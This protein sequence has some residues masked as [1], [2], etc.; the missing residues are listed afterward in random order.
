[1]SD[2][3][4]LIDALIIAG[5]A[6]WMMFPALVTGPFAVLFGGGRPIDFGRRDKKGR[7]LLGGGKTWSGLGWGV[8]G[9]VAVGCAMELIYWYA[10]DWG[11]EYLIDFSPGAGSAL[12]FVGLLLAVCLGAMFGDLLF[13]FCKRKVGLKRGKRAPLVDQLDFLAG[14]WVFMVIFYPVWT[15]DNFSAWHAI[16][17]LI[18]VPILHVITNLIAFKIG[19]KK[20]P[21]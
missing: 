1:M 12:G 15:F 3:N 17:I 20:E 11:E 19:K 18:I 7:R 6:F 9:G 10:G 5:Q 2:G 13:S 16:A 14:A 4:P 8:L 21:W